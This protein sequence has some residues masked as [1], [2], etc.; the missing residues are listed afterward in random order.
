MALTEGSEQRALEE[1]ALEFL[2]ENEERERKELQKA[3][4]VHRTRKSIS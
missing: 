2:L 1:E 3:L 4:R